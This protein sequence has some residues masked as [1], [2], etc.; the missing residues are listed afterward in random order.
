MLRHLILQAINY[1]N[2][3]SENLVS[4]QFNQQ[5]QLMDVLLNE[6]LCLK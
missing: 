1:A 6:N 4:L 2:M 3:N 5:N